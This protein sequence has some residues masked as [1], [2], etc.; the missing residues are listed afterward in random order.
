VGLISHH[1]RRNSAESCVATRDSAGKGVKMTENKTITKLIA[2]IDMLESGIED[3]E[4]N[5]S[6]LQ[7]DLQVL[8]EDMEEAI[9]IKELLEILEKLGDILGK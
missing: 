9:K 5:I 3:F 2:K 4:N 6:V 7:D 1:T 8:Q